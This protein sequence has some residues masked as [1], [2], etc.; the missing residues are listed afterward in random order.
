MSVCDP[1]FASKAIGTRKKRAE[2]KSAKYP[3]VTW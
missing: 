3:A 2:P 1:N